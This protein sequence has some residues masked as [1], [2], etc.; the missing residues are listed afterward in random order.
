[1]I[2]YPDDRIL[3][4]VMNNPQDWEIVQD[5]GWYRIPVKRAPEQI[6]DIDWLAFY[7]TAKFGSDRWAIHY[8]APVIGHELVTRADLFPDQTGH[9]RA[10]NWY[11]KMELGLLHH[12]IPPIVSHKWRRITFIVTS[13]DRFEDALEVNDLFDGESSQGRI[14]VQLK[15]AGYSVE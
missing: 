6:P 8:V 4:A 1:M 10:G 7:F 5:E 15:E 14:Y 12:K 9:P 3:I 13:G 11:Y 2:I